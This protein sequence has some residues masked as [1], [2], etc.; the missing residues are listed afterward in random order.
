MTDN[1]E[2]AGRQDHCAARGELWWWFIVGFF[3]VFVGMS[4]AIT[5]YPMHLSGR[6]VVQCRLWQYYIIEIRR[7]LRS[8]SGAFGPA[9]G[10]S[11]AALIIL[12]QHLL[13]SAAGG[14]LALGLGWGI[15]KVRGR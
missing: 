9:T 12:A 14:G 4:V 11:A 5:M 6:A 10:S 15:R 7:A 13:L 2:S 1:V 8:S 3:L